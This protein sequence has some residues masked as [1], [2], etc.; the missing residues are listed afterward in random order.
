MASKTR[1][2]TMP[3]EYITVSD[4]KDYLKISQSAAYELTHCKDFPV[5]RIGGA[6]RIPKEAFLAWVDLRTTI[7]ANLSTYMRVGA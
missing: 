2:I 4:I 1:Q 6:I 7:P 5:C 3:N